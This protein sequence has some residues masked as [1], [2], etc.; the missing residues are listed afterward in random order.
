MAD[1]LGIDF[2]VQQAGQHNPV[3]GVEVLGVLLELVQPLL[4]LRL[5]KPGLHH[6]LRLAALVQ[7]E[8]HVKADGALELLN[9]HPLRQRS[10]VLQLGERQAV[11]LAHLHVLRQ[12]RPEQVPEEAHGGVLGQRDVERVGHGRW[13]R[14]QARHAEVD[15]DLRLG[16]GDRHGLGVRRLRLGLLCRCQGRRLRLGRLRRRGGG[17]GE[18]ALQVGDEAGAEVRNHRLQA[19]QVVGAAPD[20]LH[21]GP[22]APVA[23]RLDQAFHLLQRSHAVLLPDDIEGLA[24]Q[25]R[26]ALHLL[27]ERL[28]DSQVRHEH[29]DVE[30]H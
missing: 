6:C 1:D 3:L 25:R 20:D 30:A 22:G 18:L 23:P 9:R 13:I 4:D 21:R 17:T 5:L 14:L 8:D 2:L 16:G 24:R 28:L 12:G 26:L 11:Q 7:R 27:L 19:L 29:P 10:V 15:E